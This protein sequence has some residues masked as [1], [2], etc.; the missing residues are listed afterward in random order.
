MTFGRKRWPKQLE[1]RRPENAKRRKQREAELKDQIAARADLAER[2][3]NEN[4]PRIAAVEAAVRSLT[5]RQGG[6]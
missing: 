3:T 2:K 4:A 1:R 6:G 5:A